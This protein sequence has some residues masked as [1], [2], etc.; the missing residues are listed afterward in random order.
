MSA[1]YRSTDDRESGRAAPGLRAVGAIEPSSSP[2]DVADLTRRWPDGCETP[3]AA[4]S[5]RPVVLKRAKRQCEETLPYVTLVATGAVRAGTTPDLE[6][7]NCQI[8]EI[9]VKL[10]P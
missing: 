5:G 8:A 3:A 10:S 7:W 6:N 2:G 4:E 9:P 1:K